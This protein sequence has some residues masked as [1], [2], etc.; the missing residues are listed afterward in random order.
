MFIQE[1]STVNLTLKLLNVRTK[2]NRLRVSRNNF[3]P[4]S[5]TQIGPLG[6]GPLGIKLITAKLHTGFRFFLV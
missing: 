2:K 6:M 3:L 4:C 5:A 1:L